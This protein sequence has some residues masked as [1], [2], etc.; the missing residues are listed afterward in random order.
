VITRDEWL[1]GGRLH[2]APTAT[3]PAL[4]RPRPGRAPQPI[5]PA[6]WS[7]TAVRFDVDRPTPTLLVMM[8]AFAE[9]W[10][11]TVDGRP[12]PILRANAVGRAVAVPAGA[13]RVEFSFD[14]PVFRWAARGPL[15]GWLLVLALLVVGRSNRSTT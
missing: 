15:V 11:A 12:T 14:V 5:A 13:H 3:P 9:G 7:S 10:H 4:E 2:R 1:D 8:D 6:A